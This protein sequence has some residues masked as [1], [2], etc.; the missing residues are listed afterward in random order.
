MVVQQISDS[1]LRRGEDGELFTSLSLFIL[2][3]CAHPVL[4]IQRVC[5]HLP[6]SRCPFLDL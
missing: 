6:I 2:I 1:D 3:C 4:P 5:F